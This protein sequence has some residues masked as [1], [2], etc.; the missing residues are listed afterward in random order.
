MAIEKMRLANIVGNLPD[1]DE[2]LLRCIES[3]VFSPG[4]VGEYAGQVQRVYG[5]DR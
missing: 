2:T 3:E 4:D 5:A 1:L